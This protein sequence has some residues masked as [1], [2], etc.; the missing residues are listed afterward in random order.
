MTVKT[1]K[2]FTTRAFIQD[3]K[4]M[5]FEN[6][7]WELPNSA[8]QVVKPRRNWHG[9]PDVDWNR[10]YAGYFSKTEPKMIRFVETYASRM[11][12]Q[13]WYEVQPNGEEI[14]LLKVVRDFENDSANVD[15]TFIN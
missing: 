7:G 2:T 14:Q 12:V 11:L 15:Y 10:G 5:G 6:P 9:A 4:I 8:A 1:D 13:G 3:G